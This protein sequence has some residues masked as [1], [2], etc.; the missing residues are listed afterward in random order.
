MFK[1]WP[2]TLHR[3]LIG[4]VSTASQYYHQRKV[5]LVPFL[6]NIIGHGLQIM[7]GKSD[8][9]VVTKECVFIIIA[10]NFMKTRTVLVDLVALD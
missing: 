4:A 5:L 2:P 9:F 8:G 10:M 6:H 1:S 7:H 3:D